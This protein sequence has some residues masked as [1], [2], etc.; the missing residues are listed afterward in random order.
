MRRAKRQATTI[1]SAQSIMMW[2]CSQPVAREPCMEPPITVGCRASHDESTNRHLHLQPPQRSL[3]SL[4]AT[5]S[6]AN[7]AACSA[8]DAPPTTQTSGNS[9]MQMPLL[10]LSGPLVISEAHPSVRFGHPYTLRAVAHPAP[11]TATRRQPRMTHST[12]VKLT[13]RA[14]PF[15][16]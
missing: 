13:S 10:S 6:R 16:R 2:D 8:P 12:N 1:R 15:A 7:S 3:T 4:A 14:N 5:Y 11:S 9:V